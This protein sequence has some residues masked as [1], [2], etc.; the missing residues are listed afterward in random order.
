MKKII[1]KLRKFPTASET[2]IVFN[3]VAAIK[4]GYEVVIIADKLDPTIAGTQPHLEKEFNLINRV[5]V[6]SPP[7]KFL[8]RWFEAFIFLLNPLMCFY[9]IK[10][11]RLKNQ[12][13]LQ[14][15]F[16]LK[17]YKSL[18]NNTLFH[19]HFANRE[20][21]L[22]DLKKIG[23]LQSKIVVTFHGFD[24]H[25]ISLAIEPS[26]ERDDLNAFANAITTNSNYLLEKAKKRGVDENKMT[27]VPVG[28]DLGVFQSN[29]NVTKN[30]DVIK[31]VSVG[32]LEVI[33]GHSLG[34]EAI[35]NLVELGYQVEYLIIGEGSQKAHLLKQIR[36]LKLDKV[37]TISNFLS[38][39]QIREIFID[40]NIFLFPSTTDF[41]GRKE[42]FGVVSLEAQAMALPVVGFNCGG[43]PET[44]VPDRTGYVVADGDTKALA[45]KLAFL[46]DH[47][48]VCLEMGI[49]AQEHIRENFTNDNTVNAYLKLYESV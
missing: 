28:L 17:F 9:F 48:E 8:L 1:F 25:R 22:F 30:T 2:F 43:F 21:P 32:R 19:V 39:E 3:V 14:Y 6:P 42:A 24:V 7:I 45:D 5:R 15:L 41:D 29:L 12:W 49:R 11:C 18:R 16:I 27:V 47:P 13:S 37:I 4:K 38:Q 44:L 46:I 23:F 31:I 40:S 34:I 20:K 35:S 36:S 26:D 10:Y 33:K